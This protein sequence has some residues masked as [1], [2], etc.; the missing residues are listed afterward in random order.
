[1][2]KKIILFQMVFFLFFCSASLWGNSWLIYNKASGFPD[3]R[4]LSWAVFKNQMAVGTGKGAALYDGDSCIWKT[5]IFPESLTDVEVKDLQFDDNGILWLATQKGLLSFKSGKFEIY[6]MSD[7]LPNV[8]CE[9]LQYIE[10]QIFVGCFGG[11]IAK[12]FAPNSGRTSFVAVNSRSNDPNNLLNIKSTGISGLA[13]KSASSGWFSTKGSGLYEMRGANSYELDVSSGLASD[14][15]E[16]IWAFSEKA[17]DEKI[18]A[19]TSNGLSM[20]QNGKVVTENAF[21][22]NA[23][24]LTAVVAIKKKQDQDKVR[25]SETNLRILSEFTNDRSLWVGTKS[26]GLWR[27]EDSEW[28]QYTTEN[29]QLPSDCITRLYKVG[30]RIV[31]CT[32]QGM[33]IIS[34]G[35]HSYDHYKNTGYGSKNFKTFFAFPQVKRVRKIVMGKDLWI[36]HGGGLS[37]FIGAS[38][39][40]SD[41]MEGKPD[42]S[43]SME[44]AT[45]KDEQETE[46]AGSSAPVISGGERMWQ[47]FHK[48]NDSIFSNDIT[49][50]TLDKSG[51]LWLIFEKKYLCRMRMI[52]SQNERNKGFLEDKPIWE[53]IGEVANIS[54]LGDQLRPSLELSPGEDNKKEIIEKYF[55]QG[56][57]GFFASGQT[58]GYTQPWPDSTELSCLWL[59]KKSGAIYVGTN[60]AGIYILENP[61][62]LVENLKDPF[63]WREL[64]S[65][66]LLPAGKIV[67]FAYFQAYGEASKLAVLDLNDLYLFDGEVFSKFDLN[68]RRDYTCILQD[69]NGS[70]WVG[71]R[72]GLFCIKQ[73]KT[74]LSYTK[75]NAGFQS[76]YVTSLALNPKKSGLLDLWVGTEDKGGGDD[77]GMDARDKFYYKKPPG[78]TSRTSA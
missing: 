28:T 68:A 5:I 30:A 76:D 63:S 50:M 4:V 78:S 59:D 45:I 7:G 56:T 13:L 26:N 64:G 38:G 70:L 48:D 18:I 19:A 10:N 65:K 67:G 31:V 25:F 71:A 51:Y 75:T 35:G 36:S 62:S 20:I 77:K 34:L 15:V 37:R 43:G 1:M 66:E 14:W 54:A 52:A 60:G 8:D 44:I 58:N 16:A 46:F 29:S 2:R 32:D 72:T 17:N 40:Y 3:N 6:D 23:V 47:I 21:P 41:M 33:A 57:K 49:D 53:F 73:D 27:F 39:V 74:I 61:D 22:Q 69:D 24:W 11:F 55:K 12:A 42:T 9:R